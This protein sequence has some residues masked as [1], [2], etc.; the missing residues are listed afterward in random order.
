MPENVQLATSD[1]E[2]VLRLSEDTRVELQRT[3][4]ALL[5][6]QLQALLETL[7]TCDLEQMRSF[8]QSSSGAMQ[9][10]DMVPLR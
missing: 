8:A 4:A 7:R 5:T 6:A 2:S 10:S 3:Y 9:C 1:K